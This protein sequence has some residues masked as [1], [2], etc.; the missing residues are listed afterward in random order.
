[1]PRSTLKCL[2]IYYPSILSRTELARIVMGTIFLVLSASE[3]SHSL[4]CSM[5][6]IAV[7]I[8][9]KSVRTYVSNTHAHVRMSICY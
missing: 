7:Y 4:G 8:M 3:A 2:N 5:I 6:N 9:V 1:M